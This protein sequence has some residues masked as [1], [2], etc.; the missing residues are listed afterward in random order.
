MAEP[1]RPRCHVSHETEAP[2]PPRT[3]TVASGVPAG[4]TGR[5]WRKRGR[6]GEKEAKKMQEGSNGKGCVDN[7]ALSLSTSALRPTP[8]IR[9]L[10]SNVL[11]TFE[12]DTFSHKGRRG[13]PRR[14]SRQLLAAEI[15]RRAGAAPHLLPLWE[16]VSRR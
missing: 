5:L 2:F 7:H 8:L 14:P 4:G 6:R 16:K 12:G 15:C 3:F 13:R 9:R 11:R 1:P 10:F